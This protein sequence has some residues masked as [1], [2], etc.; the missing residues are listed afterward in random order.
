VGNGFGG[1]GGEGFHL[2]LEQPVIRA[3]LDILA[4]QSFRSD[5]GEGAVGSCAPYPS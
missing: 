3:K 5:F 4:F 2:R 1:K